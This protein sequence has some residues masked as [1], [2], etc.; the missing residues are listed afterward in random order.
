MGT[1]LHIE[2]HCSV[3]SNIFSWGSQPFVK[4]QPAGNILLSGSILFSGALPTKV[5]HVLKN[6]GCATICE[7]TF[8]LHQKKHLQLS[9]SSVWERHQANLLQQ[10]H[11]EKRALIIGGDGRADSPGHSA[12][13]GSY[14]VMEL[15]KEV[16]LDVQLVQVSVY[17]ALALENTSTL[18]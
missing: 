9:I 7:R 1:Y 14:T 2:Q 11:H 18:S 17:L 6:F 4:N 13:F 12:K 10:L 16:I 5:I 3:C 15:K 8:F